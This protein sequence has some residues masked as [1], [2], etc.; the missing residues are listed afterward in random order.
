MYQLRKIYPDG[1]SAR[2]QDA[3]TL[4]E[5]QEHL[6]AYKQNRLNLGGEVKAQRTVGAEGDFFEVEDSRH[7]NAR[8]EIVK[9]R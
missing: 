7:K 4:E 5:A 2:C 9:V 1:T 6:L 3:K 8:Y